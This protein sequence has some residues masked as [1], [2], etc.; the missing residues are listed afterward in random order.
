VS[1]RLLGLTGQEVFVVDGTG[2]VGTP[3]YAGSS[4]V[5]R[6]ADLGLTW[7]QLSFDK[8]TRV[9]GIVVSP[10][11]PKIM[12]AGS[13]TGCAGGPPGAQFRSDD[14]GTTWKKL[15]AAPMSLQVD[16]K[17]PDLLTAMTCTGV[18]RSHDGGQTWTPLTD[19]DAA[20]LANH[21]GVMVRVPAATSDVIYA[22]YSS[23]GGS[24]R[25]RVSTD[26]GKT[27]GG[28]GMDYPGVSD[29]LVNANQPRQAW[30]V[31]ESCSATVCYGVLRTTDGGQSWAPSV[32]GLDAAHNTAA[33]SLGA[34]QLSSLAA[35][36]SSS[37]DLVE[38]YAGSFS[39]DSLPG[40]GVLSSRYGGKVWI[41]FGGNMEGFSIHDLLVVGEPNGNG[42]L[43]LEFLYAATNDGVQKVYLNTAH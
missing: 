36:Y 6:T 15:P 32:T 21:A 24:T 30:A 39:T 8:R 5:Y 27:W 25:I 17:N 12:Y 23:E 35:Q 38:L 22:T 43:P 16:G 33:G 3:V 19:S 37:G 40:A 20:K 28:D 26:G 4:G 42:S 18:V 29:M 31:T 14:S 2:Q 41:R 1:W 9:D 34:Y 10:A 7:A 11:N 13:G